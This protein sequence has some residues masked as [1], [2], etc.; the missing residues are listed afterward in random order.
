MADFD[1]DI[2]CSSGDPAPIKVKEGDTVTVI[3]NT[4]AD[5]EIKFNPGSVFKPEKGK[6]DLKYPGSHTFTI[7]DKKKIATYKWECPAKSELVP[8]TGRIDPS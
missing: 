2:C 1:L 4:G 6:I 3:N 7:S 5:V 8:R